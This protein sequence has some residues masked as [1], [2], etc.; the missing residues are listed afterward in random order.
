MKQTLEHTVQEATI[1]RVDQPRAHGQSFGPGGF[2]RA[3]KETGDVLSSRGRLWRGRGILVFCLRRL[4][5]Y[6]YLD[7]VMRRHETMG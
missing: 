1:A 3:R 5:R 6:L 4:G 7:G 2:H